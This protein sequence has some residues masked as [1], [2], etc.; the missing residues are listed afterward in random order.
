MLRADMQGGDLVLVFDPIFVHHWKQV[1]GRIEGVGRWQ[2]ARI[3][4]SQGRWLAPP[5]QDATLLQGGWLQ[6]GEERFDDL[7]PFPLKATG[8]V[9]GHFVPQDNSPQSLEFA[10]V[11]ITFELTGEP[12]GAEELPAE[13]APSNLR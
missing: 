8:D 3:R 5:A 4:V 10:G 2:S 9:I 7:I 12:R 1:A 6:V 11:A 13:W